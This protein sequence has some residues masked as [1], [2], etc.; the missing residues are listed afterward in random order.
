MF[1]RNGLEPA[2]VIVVVLAFALIFGWKRLPDMARSLGRSARV[3]KSEID[4]MKTDQAQ[5][6]Q[7][8]RSD[9]SNGAATGTT[10]SDARSSVGADD[11][12]AA[13]ARAAAAEE[14]VAQARAEAE[15]LRA[16]SQR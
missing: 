14:R 15:R 3:F 11:L 13:E 1:L 7:A 16:Q 2:H 5:N 8:G 9:A 12:I 6:R 4:E 10:L